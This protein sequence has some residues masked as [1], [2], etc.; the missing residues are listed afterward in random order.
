MRINNIVNQLKKDAVIRKFTVKPIAQEAGFNNS[1][2]FSKVF[3]KIKG[4]KPSYYIKNL[5]K[6]VNL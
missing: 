3:F 1:D 4:V 2:S 6:V 5:E